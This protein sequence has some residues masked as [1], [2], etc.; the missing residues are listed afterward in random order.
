MWLISFF[1]VN[2]IQTR[3]ISEEVKMSPSNWPIDKF[4]GTVS[5]LITG[6]GEPTPL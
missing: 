1:F 3:G 2:F 6:V 4:V 5:G